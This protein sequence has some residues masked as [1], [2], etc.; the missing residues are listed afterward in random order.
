M[1]VQ[2]HFSLT[3]DEKEMV[4]QFLQKMEHYFLF[5]VDHQKA[6]LHVSDSFNGG[7]TYHM[8]Q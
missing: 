6:F 3:N 5:I 8:V 2:K 1:P 4:F 7:L